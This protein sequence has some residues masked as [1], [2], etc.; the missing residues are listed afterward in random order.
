METN[1]LE[2]AAVIAKE[3][4]EKIKAPEVAKAAEEAKVASDAKAKADAETKKDEGISAAVP[5]I[6]PTPSLETSSIVPTPV[7]PLGYAGLA[8]LIG[9]A[10]GM[11]LAPWLERWYKLVL[12]KSEDVRHDNEK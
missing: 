8:A 7:S 2:R 10:A 5:A 3:N 9:I 12:K 11:L 6:E 4:L 1:V